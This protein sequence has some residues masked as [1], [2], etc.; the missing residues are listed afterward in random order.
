M[1]FVEYTGGCQCGAVRYRVEGKLSFPHI[2]HCRMCQ[3]ASGNYFAPL[4]RVSD[5]DFEVTRGEASWFYSSCLGG[6][7]DTVEAV[8][9][10][11]GQRPQYRGLGFTV[12]YPEG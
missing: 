2:C 3:K 10:R 1:S 9:P 5:D 11:P 7:P 6:F 8:Q 12:W 4:A